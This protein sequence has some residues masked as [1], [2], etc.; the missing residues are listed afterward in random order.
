MENSHPLHNEKPIALLKYSK[1]LPA[2]TIR[3]EYFELIKGFVL[4]PVETFQKV[5][6][7]DYGDSLVYFL[8]LVLINTVLS[9]PIMLVT[10]SSMWTVFNGMFQRLGLPVR[11]Q[12]RLPGDPQGTCFRGNSCPPAGVDLPGLDAW[13]DLVSGPFHP[14]GS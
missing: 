5:K 2:D 1:S 14:G 3:M 12:E 11:R 7:T 8:V 6:D 10:L 9:V 4:S 13:R